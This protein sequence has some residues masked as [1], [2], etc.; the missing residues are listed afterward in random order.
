MTSTMKGTFSLASSSWLCLRL[1]RDCA[2]LRND[3]TSGLHIALSWPFSDPYVPPVR[4]RVL[5]PPTP[6]VSFHPRSVTKLIRPAGFSSSTTGLGVM[7]LTW[8]ACY[9]RVPLVDANFM[10]SWLLT[11]N[12]SSSRPQ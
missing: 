10:T 3:Q 12:S 9:M 2:P 4:P 7:A 8:P 5:R 6:L 1:C 11:L